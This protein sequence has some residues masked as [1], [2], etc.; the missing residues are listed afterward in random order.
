MA[1]TN[2]TS[3]RH[4]KERTE[5][6]RRRLLAAAEAVFIRDGFQAAKLEDIAKAAGYTRGAFYANFQSK[7]DLFITVAERQL[8]GLTD[9]LRRAVL[10]ASGVDNKAKAVLQIVQE[11]R[12]ARRW[13]LLLLEFNLF[14]LRQPNLKG[15]VLPMQ[16]RL[17]NGI[18]AVFRDLYVAAN[19]RPPISLAVVGLG[20]GAIFQGLTLQKI[21]NGKL[22][23]SAEIAAVLNRYIDAMLSAGEG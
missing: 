7:E 9:K 15:R 11:S 16:T 1:T 21:L 18:E 3:R 17:L 8:K 23:S 14:F 19:H 12:A 5:L 22:V 2:P 13:A 6:T 10:S 20:F 4:Q